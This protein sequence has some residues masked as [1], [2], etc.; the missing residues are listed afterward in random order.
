MTRKVK[1]LSLVSIVIIL[2][3]SYHNSLKNGFLLDDNVYFD[4]KPTLAEIPNSELLTQPCKGFYRPF[5]VLFLKFEF[6]VFGETFPV[7]YHL[8]SLFLFGCICWLFFLICLRLFR[9]WEI[10]WAAMCFFAAHPINNF[11]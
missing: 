8:V 4:Y 3:L 5:A 1:I 2:L 10:P 7:G 9:Q 11:L 6:L